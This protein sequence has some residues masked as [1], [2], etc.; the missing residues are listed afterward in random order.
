[1]IN[2]HFLVVTVMQVT[3][4]TMERFSHRTHFY[5][6]CTLFMFLDVVVQFLLF[7][8]I[9][10]GSQSTIVQLCCAF[11]HLLP[12]FSLLVSIECLELMHVAQ[13]IRFG[14]ARNECVYDKMT[15]VFLPQV[16]QDE[17]F[18]LFDRL[19]LIQ[20]IPGEAQVDAQIRKLDAMIS[21]FHSISV[22]SMRVRFLLLLWF[23]S[24]HCM[25]VCV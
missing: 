14:Y 12:S 3:S 5:F 21:G 2:V 10:V 24:R 15:D 9:Q 13:V 18:H 4:V 23:R 19:R 11:E 8:I 7:L 1:M 22:Q 17:L 16:F 25:C 20:E 6:V